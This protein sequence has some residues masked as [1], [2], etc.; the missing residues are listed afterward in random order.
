MGDLAAKNKIE[1]CSNY[2]Y[3]YLEEDN[4]IYDD[5]YPHPS[6]SKINSII[7]NMNKYDW[8]FWS[9]VDS[10]IMNFNTRLHE[11]VDDNYNFIGS[12]FYS[13]YAKCNVL[14][15]GNFLIKCDELSKTILNE[16]FETLNSGHMLREEWGLSKTLLKR[17][18]N[19]YVKLYP[20]KTFA[21]WVKDKYFHNGNICE[22]DVDDWYPYHE[23]D[24]I[25]HFGA[26]IPFDG[27][28]FL[29]KK[30]LGLVVKY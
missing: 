11:F 10:L 6:W 15:T 20:E 16:S 8:I 1:Y 5:L 30:Y 18:I 3:D 22:V 7:N 25:N 17:G 24:F 2:G 13:T 28:I 27:R 4:S 14:H 12:I 19:D 26:V 23:G 21:T 9:D 29:M